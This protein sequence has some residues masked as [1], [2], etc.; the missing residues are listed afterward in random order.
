MTQT[1]KAVL[2]IICAK[3]WT[4]SAHKTKQHRQA[5]VH[6]DSEL[7]KKE[8]RMTG[9]STTLTTEI[10]FGLEHKEVI[11]KRQLLQQNVWLA[12]EVSKAYTWLMKIE[13]YLMSS[14]WKLSAS[15]LPLTAWWS[16]VRAVPTQSSFP[17]LQS[18]SAPH[19]EWKTPAESLSLSDISIVGIIL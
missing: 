8:S 9:V 10:T 17:S 15:G 19:L 18:L 11:H 5:N 3:M 14:R 4:I 2:Y 16:C 13:N 1:Q 12:A 6:K 7:Y